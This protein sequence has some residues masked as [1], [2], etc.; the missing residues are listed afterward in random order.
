MRLVRSLAT[1]LT[2]AMGCAV[3]AAAQEIGGVR[4]GDPVP[5]TMPVPD[6]SQIDGAF[7][8]RLWQLESGVSLSATSDAETGEVLY[9]EMWPGA[10]GTTPDAPVQGFTYGVTTRDD[11]EA[12]FGSEGIV[13]SDRGRTAALETIAAYFV[14]YEVAGS[15]VVVA[16]VTMQPLVDAS[17]ET[18]GQSVLDSVIVAR[19]SYLDL[20]WG[21]NRGR[22]PGYVPIPDPF[23]E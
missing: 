23:V 1:A 10:M 9:I 11:I 14:A 15:D 16:F 18:A 5:E 7:S 21:G 4:L 8:Y 2:L 6:G 19:G 20:I 3:P 17:A 22:L 13:F 12:R